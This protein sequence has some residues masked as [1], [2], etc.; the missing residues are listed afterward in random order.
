MLSIYQDVSGVLW[1]GTSGG[2][3]NRFENGKFRAYTTHD[4]LSSDVVYSILG[5]P[6]GT[7]WFGTYGGL[8]RF[9]NQKFSF[10]PDERGPKNESLF[11]ILDD[12]M[13]NFWISSNKG[14]L[15]YSKKQLNDFADG[16]VASVVPTLYDHRDGM[17]NEECN[18][19]FNPAGW[20]TKDGRLL[21]P[22]MGGL[23][24]ID[25]SKI[26]SAI[27]L[28]PV[29]LENILIDNKSYP[30]GS[31]LTIPPGNGRLE[32]QFTAPTFQNADRLQFRYQLEGFDTDW[33]RAGTRRVAYYTNIPHGKYRFRVQ[34]SSGGDW[35]N[36]EIDIGLTLRPHFYQTTTFYLLI[37]ILVVTACLSG[38]RIRVSALKMRE[39]RLVQ[40][41]NERTSALQ[42]SEGRLR[43]SRDELEIRV[44]ERTEDLVNLN[45]ALQVEIL[46][47]KQTEGEL[48]LAKDAAEAASRAKSD[49][50]SNMSHEIRTPINGILG[51]TDITLS[52]DLDPEQRDYLE[53]VKYSADS[54]LGIVNDILDFSK[55]EARKFTLD[56]TPFSLRDST[57]ELIR[58]LRWRASEKKLALNVVIAE[59][60]PDKITGDS[61][62]TRQVLLNLLDNSIKFTKKG[63]VSLAVS[64]DGT[65]DGKSALH[66][67]VTDT[68]IGI[69][70]G[71]QKSIF[72]AFSQ[73]DTSSTR[74][75]GGTGLGLTISY[76]L[77]L[78][79]GGRLWV[80][81]E[82]DKG[83]TFH[84]TALVDTN[85]G[86]LRPDDL[87]LYEE[88]GRPEI[89]MA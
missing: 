51:M 24:V 27:A 25:P 64:L 61:L 33:I 66:F 57:N 52:T 82:P 5:D 77:A 10:F 7:L 45:H 65:S 58:S 40:L 80:E 63:S 87:R 9:R 60:V 35:G 38:Y 47:R 37:V 71:K 26:P 16:R 81:S 20:H 41:V 29:I 14:I 62:R 76:Q 78:M 18:G 11:H 15:R 49:F 55:I 8:N 48:T 53:T 89:T 30:A 46:V 28:P 1:F 4:G 74:S 50:L 3:V 44:Q 59:D 13:G 69:A 54:L 43:Q 70:E 2:G 83:S 42:E 56:H 39:Q 6:D 79:M 22:T 67:A 21:F 12:G 68:G 75:Y 34:V 86:P 73:A 85:S 32:I 72:E 17:K 19:G 31:D 36:R 88:A 23:V 84:F